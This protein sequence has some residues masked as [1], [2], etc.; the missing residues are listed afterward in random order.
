MDIN[1]L[2]K[3]ELQYELRLRGM[4]FDNKTVAELRSCLRPLL[5]FE[6]SDES[7][8]YP[9]YDFDVDEELVIIQGKLGEINSSVVQFS[10]SKTDG[11]FLTLN[12][13]LVHLL[14]RTDR[15]PRTETNSNQRS[16]LMGK[17]FEL[18]DD[19][20]RATKCRDPSTNIS[21]LF[22]N[23]D[24]EASDGSVSEVGARGVSLNV[25][26]E[27]STSRQRFQP[28]QKWNLRFSGE[29][30]TVTVH[31]FLE[32]VD[33]LRL[34]RGISELELFESAIDLFEGKALL[35]YRAN[36]SRFSDW[37][38]L[39][40][41]L[42]KHYEPPD[43]KNRLLQEIM[44][45]TQD[46]SESIVDYLACMNAMFR[47]YGSL[48]EDVQLGM[49][50]RNLA[51][52]YTMQL[53][54]IRNLQQLEDECLIL[55]TKKFRAD[56]Y[57]PPSAKKSTHVEPDFA[58]IQSS[59]SQLTLD[60]QQTS[61]SSNFNA[62]NSSVHANVTCFNCRKQGH[63]V[64]QCTEPYVKRCYRCGKLNHTTRTCPACNSN[65]GNSFRR[66][67]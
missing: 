18:F 64:Q 2:K 7:L 21:S 9:D 24:D 53:P 55:E 63:L 16:E 65:S 44:S 33:E 11:V 51:P 48:S 67:Q 52:F 66:N 19:L 20:E 4:P 45:R 35:W 40:R 8:H 29:S 10:G 58:F 38:S 49:I 54:V 13:R 34:A 22:R 60:V 28:V 39:A 32:R 6:K 47:R 12:S 36:R 3:D 57:K 15:L 25:S 50:M 31:N 46:N 43:Y 17:I 61:P 30:K 62:L 1:R 14:K 37:N 5:K 26:N 27:A 59:T 23:E 42:C 56:S 41:L